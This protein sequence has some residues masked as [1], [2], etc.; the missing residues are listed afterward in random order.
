[1]AIS[2]LKIVLHAPTAGALVRARN[3]LA[4]PD[5]TSPVPEVRIVVNAEAV[6]ATLDNPNDVADRVTQVCGNTLR[7][8]GRQASTPLTVFDQGAVL[9]LAE[10]QAD[11][12]RYI[13]A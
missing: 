6:A 10:M 11:G 2:R 9:G 7:K 1:M 12:W 4:N 8:L 3:N 13:R 5:S